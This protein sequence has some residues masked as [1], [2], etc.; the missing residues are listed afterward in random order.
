MSAEYRARIEAA[1][2]Q[3][4]QTAREQ[5]GLAINPGPFGI[6]TRAA[7]Q[8]AAA[9]AAAGF[10]DRLHRA[11]LDA[12]WL[13]GRDISDHAVLADIAEQVG[14]GAERCRAVLADPAVDA[15]VA[16]DIA[17]ARAYNLQAV[18]ATVINQRYLISGAQP[19]AVM[20]RYLQQVESMP[21]E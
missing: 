4:L 15:A 18:P 16:A 19:L 13:A 21:A 11:L 3:L 17:E 9:A 7:H 6:S 1:R 5:Y 20:R 8:L 14:F 2:P 10:A 12:Y